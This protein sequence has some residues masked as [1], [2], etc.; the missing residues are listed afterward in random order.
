V[1]YE[2]YRGTAIRRFTPFLHCQYARRSSSRC[3]NSPS[4]HMHRR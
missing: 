2:F 4:S 1:L 3:T